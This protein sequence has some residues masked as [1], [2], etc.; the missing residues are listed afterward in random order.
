MN[1]RKTLATAAGCHSNGSTLNSVLT[2]QFPKDIF[3]E[4][5]QFDTPQLSSHR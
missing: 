3:N 2:L 5:I 4:S 1:Q